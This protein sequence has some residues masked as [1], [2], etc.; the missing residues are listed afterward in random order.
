MPLKNISISMERIIHI[1]FRYIKYELFFACF[2]SWGILSEAVHGITRNMIPMGKLDTLLLYTLMLLLFLKVFS[3]FYSRLRG[4]Q[5]V[6]AI[7]LISLLLIATLFSSSQDINWVVITKVIVIC[8]PCF[9]LA[10]CLRD[11]SSLY[12]YL[13]L[14]MQIAPYFLLLSFLFLGNG[15]LEEDENYSQH[16]SYLHLFPALVLLSDVLSK[17]SLKSFIPFVICVFLIIA[18]GARGPLASLVL[19]AFLYWIIMAKSIGVKKMVLP[20]IIFALIGSYVIIHLEAVIMYL[21][22]LMSSMN[23]SVRVLNMV[24]AEPG[25]FAESNAR[26]DYAATCMTHVLDNPFW[27]TGPINDR[28]FLGNIYRS[29]KG[30]DGLYPHN[31]FVEIFTQYGLFLGFVIII[32]FLFFIYKSLKL[33]INEE[34]RKLLLVFIGAYFFPLMFSGSYVD[35]NGFYILVASCIVIRHAGKVK[36]LSYV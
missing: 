32:Y 30:I 33:S 27:C 15:Q 34:T 35:S 29:D 9:I 7:C 2:L 31:F 8:L 3:T 14:I 28:V 12:K 20:I 36:Q 16:L 18:Y 26:E 24:M 4:W 19:F 22:D 11:F 25:S 1:D 13:L 6:S 5:F 17:F 23:T 10:G 21:A